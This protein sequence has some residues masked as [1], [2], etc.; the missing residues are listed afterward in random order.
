[1]IQISCT[2]ERKQ[3]YG[4]DRKGNQRFKCCLCGQTFGIETAKPLG[5]MRITMKEATTILGLLVEGM[6]V[7]AVERLTGTCRKT[8]CDL[9]LV[10]G[11][12]CERLLESKVQSVVDEVQLDRAWHNRGMNRSLRVRP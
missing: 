1:M 10:V 2:H 9:I 7:R 8:I 12:N 3:K 5:D 6:S 11:D 4:K